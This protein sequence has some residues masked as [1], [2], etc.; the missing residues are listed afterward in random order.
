MSGGRDEVGHA[1]S[2]VALLVFVLAHLATQL[3]PSLTA[4]L[5]EGREL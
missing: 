5:M 1:A 2:I 3:L 4:W